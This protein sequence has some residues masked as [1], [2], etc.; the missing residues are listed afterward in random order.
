MS[1]V[2]QQIPGD[3][4]QGV[5]DLGHDLE[6]SLIWQGRE[7]VVDVA[8]SATA[9]APHGLKRAYRGAI[10]IGASTGGLDPVAMRPQA[11][12]SAGVDITTT[13][14]VLLSGSGTVTVTMW[15]F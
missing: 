13:I 6:R 8:A 5:V 9:D 1:G 15:V 7:V 10:V 3:A 11:A 12:L 14:R 4:L 2:E